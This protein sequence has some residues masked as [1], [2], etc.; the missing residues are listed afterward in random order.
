MAMAKHITLIMYTLEEAPAQRYASPIFVREGIFRTRPFW[1]D[2]HKW[3]AEGA[4][5][6]LR[7]PTAQEAEAMRPELEQIRQSR[8]IRQQS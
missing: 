7:P 2:I 6:V 1:D 4:T 8:S 5:V 3:V